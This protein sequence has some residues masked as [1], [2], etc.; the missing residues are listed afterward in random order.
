MTN[1]GTD[2]RDFRTPEKPGRQHCIREGGDGFSNIIQINGRLFGREVRGFDAFPLS[3]QKVVRGMRAAR[4]NAA[5]VG[6]SW[7]EVKFRTLHLN[8]VTVIET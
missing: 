7:A 3:S 5:S 8:F 6:N 1:S 2:G 4:I